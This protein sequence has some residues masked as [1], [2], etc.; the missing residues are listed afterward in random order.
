MGALELAAAAAATEELLFILRGGGVAAKGEAARLPVWNML[1]SA[2]ITGEQSN[3]GAIMT[4]LVKSCVKH[5]VKLCLIAG[6]FEGASSRRSVQAAGGR[7]KG[8][9]RA[10]AKAKGGGAG[11]AAFGAL[12]QAAVSGRDVGLGPF[13][14]LGKLLYNK[15]LDPSDAVRACSTQFS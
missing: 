3:L 5:C 12:L 1:W 9:P 13:H 7:R 4:P 15:R 6:A 8:R 2:W 11:E 14:A 10:K